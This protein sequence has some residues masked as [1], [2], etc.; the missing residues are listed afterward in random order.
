VEQEAQG[1]E[2]ASN[3]IDLIAAEL[4]AEEEP[5]PEARQQEAVYSQVPSEPGL[6][7]RQR[8]GTQEGCQR[9]HGE[10]S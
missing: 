5:A 6:S 2:R 10:G 3:G 7:I 4:G 8:E 9:K 1:A